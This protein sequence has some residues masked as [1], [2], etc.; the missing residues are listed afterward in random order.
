MTAP[1]SHGV[2][3]TPPSTCLASPAFIQKAIIVPILF[4]ISFPFQIVKMETRFAFPCF[5]C[6]LF[7]NNAQKLVQRD[8]E[9]ATENPVSHDRSSA[10]VSCGKRKRR[11]KQ[12][13]QRLQLS[14]FLL[15]SSSPK[16]TSY[17]HLSKAPP[18]IGKS[19]HL[20]RYRKELEKDW[21]RRDKYSSGLVTGLRG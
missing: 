1:H 3:P 21:T 8:S 2:T 18:A 20:R 6:F 13:M 7:I 19:A 17:L 4:F 16:A 10:P 12:Q 5:I 14:L 11:K 15:I 9:R